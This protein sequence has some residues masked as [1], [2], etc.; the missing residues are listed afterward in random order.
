MVEGGA[1]QC[2]PPKCVAILKA[3]SNHK[4]RYAAGVIP[5]ENRRW[6]YW[7]LALAAACLVVF[8]AIPGLFGS[9]KGEA[10]SAKCAPYRE[11]S[12]DHGEHRD[13]S[14]RI[15]ASRE[16]NGDCSAWLLKVQFLPQGI[17]RGSWTGGWAISAHGHLPTTATIGAG[18]YGEDDG[19]SVGGVTGIH[20]RTVVLKL[21]GG[22][23]MVVHPKKPHGRL[24]TSFVWLRDLR[25]FL[26]FYPAG[27][28]VKMAKLFDAHGKRLSTVH[29]EEGVL[30]GFMGL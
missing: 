26:R 23:T 1:S 28:H 29:S 15:K 12:L 11:V 17:S 6:A 4:M 5:K 2:L 16:K 3:D 14:W 20:V 13:R 10:A 27:E 22:D 7:L 30:E 9:D 25:Y 18:D 24:L 21:S 19:R 8:Y